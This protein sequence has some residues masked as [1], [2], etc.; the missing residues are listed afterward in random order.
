[1]RPRVGRGRSGRAMSVHVMGVG[2]QPLLPGSLRCFGNWRFCHLY[3]QALFGRRPPSFGQGRRE[4]LPVLGQEG[5]RMEGAQP[6]L[7]ARRPSCLLPPELVSHW[8]VC[9]GLLPR[10]PAK[11][12]HAGDLKAP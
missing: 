6:P 8:C 11:M 3:A 10:A 7:P 4:P 12:G 2:C 5:V 1:M 9:E